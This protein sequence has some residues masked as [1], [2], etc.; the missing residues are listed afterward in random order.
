MTLSL[1]NII[2]YDLLSFNFN[3]GIMKKNC[4][5]L[6]FLLILTIPMIFVGCQNNSESKSEESTDKI[7]SKDS[8]EG[9]NDLLNFA[10]SVDPD[11][12][13]PQR[14]TAASTFQ[15]TSN[16]YDTLVDVSSD[17]EYE[18]ALAESWEISDDGLDITFKLK[19][20]IKFHNAKEFNAEAVKA[21]FER[22]KDTDSPRASDYENIIGIEVLS[23]DEIKF[24][25]KELDVEL[26]SKFAYPWAAI[27][28]VSSAS[29]LKNNPVG[30]GAYMLEEWIPQEKLVLKKFDD[31]PSQANIQK[32]VMK[33][34]PDPQ[35]KILALESGEIDIADIDGMQV[36]MVKSIDGYK[37]EENSK[38]GLQ[39]MAM[40]N[41]NEYLS[42]K[43]V[44]QAIT[45][46][47]NKDSLIENVW[48]GYGEKIGSH[49]PPILKEYVDY[50]KSLSY[51]LDSAKKLMAEAGYPDGFTLKMYLP[52]D[53]PAYV[54]AGQLIAEDLKAI[55]INCE[56][57]IVEWAYWLE[58][59]YQGRNY[60]LTVVGHTGR[61]DP[62]Q[63]LARYESDSPENYVNFSNPRVDEILKTAPKTMDEKERIEM[64]KEL[65]GI[66]SEE[67]PALYIQSPVIITAMK[68]SL[69]GYKSYPIDIYRLRDLKFK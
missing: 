36:E 67:V 40:N 66:L 60:D 52:K 33:T 54:D 46:A 41:K 6:I 7:E 55:N 17:G 25:T 12:L 2:R 23:D 4:K 30:T 48:Y 49:Y 32:V 47:V 63:W 22:L 38:N 3:G 29:D 42:N 62:Y 68:D 15:I 65:Q 26:L 39:L 19:K 1:I 45:K 11:G 37:I 58:S 16:I 27:V 5:F 34:I 10:I 69:S 13:D 51:D 31:G 14:T 43:K 8:Q 21:S 44:R 50:S 9:K 64:Y 57:E 18:P 59:V 61:L 53:Y 24:L 28:E 35:A 20:D 56:I